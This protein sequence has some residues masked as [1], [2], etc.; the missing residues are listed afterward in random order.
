MQYGLLAFASTSLFLTLV[1]QPETCHPGTRGVDKIVETEGKAKWVW[2]NP[3][4]SLA[5]LRS[6]NVLLLASHLAV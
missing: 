6:P 5:L 3:F 1:L 2:L 4:K